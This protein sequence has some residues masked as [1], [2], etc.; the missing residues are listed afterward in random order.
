MAASRAAVE[1]KSGTKTIS[2]SAGVRSGSSLARS[3]MTQPAI[4]LTIPPTSA[5]GTIA[6]CLPRSPRRRVT[7]RVKA[8]IASSIA[9][10]RG[11]PGRRRVDQQQASPLRLGGEVV[12][13]G[14]DGGGDLVGAASLWGR[15]V[16]GGGEE[17]HEGLVERGRPRVFLG[18]EVL[19]EGLVR[20]AGGGDQV[21][22]RGRLEAVLGRDRQDRLE[23]PHALMALD[24]RRRQAVATAREGEREGRRGV[25]A[26]R[27]PCPALR[28]RP[29]RGA[30][31][32]GLIQR[33]P[34]GEVQ[35]RGAQRAQLAGTQVTIEDRDRPAGQDGER[36]LGDRRAPLRRGGAAQQLL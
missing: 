36:R 25:V 7:R 31:R 10:V 32:V 21:A 8:S 20:E 33:A 24:E 16:P 22:H 3:S 15:G 29:G 4:R 14:A 27:G 13:A 11:A 17:L 2:T 9:G 5:N 28:R 26:R 19:V 34:C 23:D 1:P 12:E 18:G 30:R 35:R 6:D